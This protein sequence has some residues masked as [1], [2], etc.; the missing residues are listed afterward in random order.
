MVNLLKYSNELNLSQNFQSTLGLSQD[1]LFAYE[2]LGDSFI[3]IFE[4]DTLSLMNFKAY[5][6]IKAAKTNAYCDFRSHIAEQGVLRHVGLVILLHLSFFSLFRGIPVVSGLAKSVQGLLI[7]YLAEYET[8]TSTNKLV[9]PL[10]ASNS[11]YE[12]SA[13]ASLNEIFDYIIVGSGPGAAISAQK[14]DSSSRILVIEQGGIPKTPTSRHHTL[15][16]VRNDFFK[17]G[18][19]I[20]LSPWLPQFAQASVLGGGSEVN[21]GLYHD[22]PISLLDTFL[23]VSGISLGAYLKSQKEIRSL[24]QLSQMKVNA[25]NSPIAR[26]AIELGYEYQNIPRWRTYTENSGFIQHGMID[27]VWN[28]MI[29]R[30]NFLFQLNTKVRKINIRNKTSIEVTCTNSEGST[31]IFFT[32][33]LIVAAGAIQTPKLLCQTGLLNWGLTDFQWHPMIRTIINTFPDDLGLHDVDPFQAWTDDRKF[34]FGSAVSTAGLLAINLD[35]RPEQDELPKLRSIYGSFVSSGRGGLIPGTGIPFY[36]PSPNDRKNAE[37]VRSLLENVVVASGATFANPTQKIKKNI[38]TV[39]IF[40]TL[41]IN[42]GAFIEGTSRLK[43]EPRIQVSDGSL[44]PFGPG[45]NPQGVIMALCDSIVA[46]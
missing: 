21:S 26:S 17:G 20:A 30:E 7:G 22:L 25:G 4:F 35:R 15:E 42:C 9:E 16:H 27:V 6:S 33:N 10:S 45:V 40:G 24:L 14:L 36:F 32:R 38:S 29:H 43:N 2:L 8:N 28:K 19:E 39:H 34:K 23:G 12:G 46:R 37:E 1:F 13:K 11:G 18:Q 5:Q 44:L 3:F 31:I 41:P